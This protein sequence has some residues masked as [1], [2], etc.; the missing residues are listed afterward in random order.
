MNGHVRRART[1]VID[2][3][4]TLDRMQA[5]LRNMEKQ[6]EW[7][8]AERDEAGAAAQTEA[9]DLSA[10]LR[11]SE[12]ALTRLRVGSGLCR[13]ALPG[14]HVISELE[15]LWS[16]SADYTPAWN[17]CLRHQAP[18]KATKLCLHV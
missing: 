1:S 15:S 9:C 13:G 3:H 8:R 17:C 5:K 11:E 16:G 6:V 4:P 18:V 10:R 14:E 2:S 7:V 12:A